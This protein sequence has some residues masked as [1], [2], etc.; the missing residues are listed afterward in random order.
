MHGARDDLLRQRRF[1]LL[2]DGALERPRAVHRVVAAVR[3][4]VAR[5]VGEV[6]G[7]VAVGQPLLEPAEL[8]VDDLPDVVALERVED[9]D[10]VDAVQELGAEVLAQRLHHLVANRVVRAARG[11]DRLAAE[12][13]RHDDDRVLEVDR[14]PLAVGQAA[15]VEQLQ[16][17]VEHVRVRLLDLV[18]EE[19][20]VG[21]AA[22]RL[23]ELAA[24][25]VADVSRRRA[26]QPGHGVL[27]H[28]FRHVDADHRLLVVE[29]ELGERAS[30]LGLADAGGAQEDERAD[31]PVRVLDAGAGADDR[32]RPRPAPPRPDR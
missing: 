2:L 11:G 22:N 14:A 24:L 15:V 1:D 28:V 16:Q 7:E 20:A 8:D 26:D 12:V 5:G 6:E 10:V 31:R 3:Q 9:D 21:T 25:L 32:V 17:D 19:H 13:G 23:G 18:E 29:Q 27:L 4:I 30:Q